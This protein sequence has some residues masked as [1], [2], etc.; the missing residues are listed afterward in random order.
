MYHNTSKAIVEIQITNSDNLKDF[1]I[2]SKTN[3][4]M[5][6]SSGSVAFPGSEIGRQLLNFT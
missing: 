2:K 4:S 3:P 1:F 5:L 6:K